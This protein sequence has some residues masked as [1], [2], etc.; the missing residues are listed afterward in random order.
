MIVY[1]VVPYMFL[2][3]GTLI[4]H[5]NKYVTT[6]D[7]HY[8]VEETTIGAR[9]HNFIWNWLF[10]MIM[11]GWGLYEYRISCVDSLDNT[12]IG[13]LSFF[14]LVGAGSFSVFGI[15]RCCFY[16]VSDYPEDGQHHHVIS[17]RGTYYPVV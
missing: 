7:G 8:G 3:K 9:Y 2:N 1:L 11:F 5:V 4:I 14:V 12:W 6:Q 16:G 10:A 17:E 15:L 13:L